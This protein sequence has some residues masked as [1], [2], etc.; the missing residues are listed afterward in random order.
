MLHRLML[1]GDTNYSEA[2]NKYY[3]EELHTNCTN[4][5]KQ[6]HCELNIN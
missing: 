6:H 3:H 4:A 2:V 1:Q 5:Q